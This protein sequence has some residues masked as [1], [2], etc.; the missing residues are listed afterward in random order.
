MYYSYKILESLPMKYPLYLSSS[1]QSRQMLLNQA[2]IPF[3]LIKQ[4]AD[5]SKC[6]WH[7][8]LPEVVKNI[9][10]YKMAHSIMPDGKEGDVCF[11]LTADTLTLDAHDTIQGKPTDRQ[12]AIK[13]LR[14]IRDGFVTAGT[15]FCLERKKYSD[16]RWHTQERIVEYV[17]A[18]YL[19]QVPDECIDAYLDQ[20]VGLAASGAIG[21]ETY[22]GQF[23]KEIRGSYTAVVGMPLFELRLS[24]EKLGFY[25]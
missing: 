15:A 2:Q 12:D 17:K 1:S 5:E 23:L 6:D 14:A 18:E 25:S 22:G 11:V 9:A 20:S 7:L 8:S 21:I 13:K 4:S 16:G 10:Q 19:F 3:T 24:L